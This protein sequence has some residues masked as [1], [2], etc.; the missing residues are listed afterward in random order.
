MGWFFLIKA[1][2]IIIPSPPSFDNPSPA[3]FQCVLTAGFVNYVMSS[4]G[5]PCGLLCIT[6]CKLCISVEERGVL[7]HFLPFY[8]AKFPLLR[9]PH[10]VYKLAFRKRIPCHTASFSPL[11]QKN[12]SWFSKQI[13]R[14]L[15]AVR[16]ANMPKRRRRS[17][18]AEGSP[19]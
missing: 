11:Q 16:R 2:K 3:G 8:P 18:R 10:Y 7:F 13:R 19:P 1:V 12:T 9:H 5:H 4:C 6:L 17:E 15:C 14:C